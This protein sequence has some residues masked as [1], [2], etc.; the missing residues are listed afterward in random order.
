MDQITDDRP[1][2][3][4][5]QLEKLILRASED[6]QLHTDLANQFDGF[7]G[8]QNAILADKSNAL[9]SALRELQKRRAADQAKEEPT[10]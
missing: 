4:D 8:M 1:R 10:P 3:T 5:A 6:E 2:V 7:A 9:V